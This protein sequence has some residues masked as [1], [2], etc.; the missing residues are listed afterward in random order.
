MIYNMID[1]SSRKV[2]ILAYC[3]AT[4]T[5]SIFLPKGDN[6]AGLAVIGG[7]CGYWFT[8]IVSGIGISVVIYL[9]RIIFNR[10]NQFEFF[11]NTLWCSTCVFAI[12]SVAGMLSAQATKYTSFTDYL[13]SGLM[14]NLV[15][16]VI[17]IFLF[18]KK[19]EVADKTCVDELS[20]TSEVST[21]KQE[22]SWLEKFLSMEPTEKQEHVKEQTVSSSAKVEKRERVDISRILGFW[23][24][25]PNTSSDVIKN[26]EAKNTTSV[27]YY[28]A[29]G[30]NPIG[31]LSLEILLQSKIATDTLVWKTGMSK[32][33]PA[34]DF[35]E[36]QQYLHSVPPPVE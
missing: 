7:I 21:P 29:E 2:N 5:T 25:K 17:A 32:W 12:F 6:L 36:L 15:Y 28:Y 23:D 33:M 9:I 10:K 1:F 24:N 27:E 14:Y 8:F 11:M 13:S 18:Y 19:K 22:K 4:L 30:K 3:L 26:S 34:K 31:P 35:P 16:L 20:T